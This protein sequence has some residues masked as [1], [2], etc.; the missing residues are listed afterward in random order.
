M[1]SVRLGVG[2]EWLLDE[3]MFRVV[4]QL[5]PDNF[6]AEDLKFRREQHGFRRRTAR[7]ICRRPT[8]VRIARR[9]RGA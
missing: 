2:T 4:R 5:G 8:T 6:V 9:R 3:R 1:G 7:V